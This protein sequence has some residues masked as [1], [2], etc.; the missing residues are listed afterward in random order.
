MPINRSPTKPSATTKLSCL[1]LQHSSSEPNIAVNRQTNNPDG[2]SLCITSRAKRKCSDSRSDLN[3]DLSAFM[4]EIRTMISDFKDQQ[5]KNMEK[6]YET[7]EKI[8]MQNSDIQLSI[9]FLSQNYE[10][11]KHQ[12]DQLQ[13]DRNNNLIHIR[14]LED[15]LERMERSAGSTCVEIRN[16]PVKKQESKEDLLNTVIKTGA[17][18]NV[19]IQPHEVKNVFRVTARDPSNKTVIVDF[20]SNIL[21]EKF[22]QMSKRYR[23]EGKSL[24]TEH[25]KISGPSKPL[26]ISENLS[27][28][29]K[30]LFYFARDFSKSNGY[31]Y[32]WTVNGKIFIRKNDGDTLHYIKDEI[33]LQN[34]SAA[35]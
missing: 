27:P 20:N 2:E 33:D 10:I 19:S 5:N 34:L 29:M 3:N 7:V 16:I 11:L 21:K 31:R 4:L 17:I 8:K 24:T 28:K 15:K 35:K 30:R 13:A 23:K 26:F 22:I 9:N 6:I 18:I 32:C 25:L 14:E 1:T 12:I